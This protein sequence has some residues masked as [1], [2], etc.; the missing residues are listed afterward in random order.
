MGVA[1]TSPVRLKWRL[2]L[3]TSMAN[4]VFDKAME[5]WSVNKDGSLTTEAARECAILPLRTDQRVAMRLAFGFDN[6]RRQVS[7]TTKDARRI[8]AQLALAAD[9]A[10]G[11][12]KGSN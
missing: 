3:G 4:E 2:N 10:D 12:I 1:S 7:F 5:G 11:L 9:V 8:A 6:E